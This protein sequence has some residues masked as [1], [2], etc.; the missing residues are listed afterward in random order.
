MMSKNR[1][2]CLQFVGSGRACSDGLSILCHAH[3][4]SRIGEA[5]ADWL[6]DQS[7]ESDHWNE[8]NL[9]GVL[10]GDSAMAALVQRLVQRG[11]WCQSESRVS[12]WFLPTNQGLDPYLSEFGK[13]RRRQFRQHLERFHEMPGL[14]YSVAQDQPTLTTEL[15]GLIDL[16]QKRWN[17]V[18][19][20]GTYADPAFRN[21]IHEAAELLLL[22]N[23]LRLVTLKQGKNL[24]AA[25]LQMISSDRSL[26]IYSSG[27]ALDRSD[28]EPGRMLD[29][30]TIAYAMAEQ[31]S[32]IDYLRGDEPYKA[33]LHA[34]PTPIVRVKAF[35]KHRMGRLERRLYQSTFEARQWIRR[36]RGSD[37][38]QVL[39]DLQAPKRPDVHPIDVVRYEAPHEPTAG[40]GEP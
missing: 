20:P 13:T 32:G 6:V 36:R 19:Q 30:K 15:A 24:V 38:V 22:R 1:R 26:A 34:V 18:G 8:L 29:A 39:A 11:I 35:A 31:M 10:Q 27:M 40:L 17:A 2:R 7:T 37:V 23:Q 14:E 21:F 5:V 16:H 33:N 4:A 25:Q 28:L 12:S 3:D 9:D